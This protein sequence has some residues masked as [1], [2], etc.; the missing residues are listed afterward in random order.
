MELRLFPFW[1]FL[2]EVPLND[3]S[4]EVA[5]DMAVWKQRA[6]KPARQTLFNIPPG[7][8]GR[9]GRLCWLSSVLCAGSEG[10]RYC[11]AG[12]SGFN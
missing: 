3:S 6:S 8:N 7:R 5:K 9:Y 11:M 10:C 1:V 2:L 12:T 4:V